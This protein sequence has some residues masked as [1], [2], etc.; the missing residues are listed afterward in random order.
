[1]NRLAPRQMNQLSTAAS[2]DRDVC[3]PESKEQFTFAGSVQRRWYICRKMALAVNTLE[4]TGFP[5]VGKKTGISD[6]RESFRKHMRKKP[7]NKLHRRKGDGLLC[8]GI[9]VRY[10]ESDG[11]SVIIHD[12]TVGDSSAKSVSGQILNGV[13]VSVKGPD[14]ITHPSRCVQL[15]AEGRPSV[16]IGIDI[17]FRKNQK[18]L[19]P[20]DFYSGHKFP[21]EQFRQSWHRQ[22][23]SAFV[24]RFLLSISGSI[25]LGNKLSQRIQTA[26]GHNHVDVVMRKKILP[27]GVQD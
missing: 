3:V 8:S 26:A 24:Y 15:F 20:E 11:F 21:A 14:N 19:L 2:A 12:S 10:R 25:V 17:C 16:G 9:P 6:T 22:E 4:L 23:E 7:A 27:P 5:C 18:I 13:A 1:M